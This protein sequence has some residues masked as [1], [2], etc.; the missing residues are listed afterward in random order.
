MVIQRGVGWFRLMKHLRVDLVQC[1]YSIRRTMCIQYSVQCR[2]YRL[3]R[4]LYTRTLYVHF[5]YS[6]QCTPYSVRTVY[7]VQFTYSTQCRILYVS[8]SFNGC[9]YTMYISIHARIISLRTRLYCIIRAYNIQCKKYTVRT[10]YDVHCSYSLRTVYSVVHCMSQGR[11]MDARIHARIISLRTRLYC[12]I[13]V[14][15]TVYGVRRIW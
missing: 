3:R 7:D 1:T 12:F 13:R 10:V 2:T 5:T 6:V 14:Q 8:R 15:Y 9:A 4:T 11:S